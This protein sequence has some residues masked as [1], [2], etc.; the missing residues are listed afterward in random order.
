MSSS[1]GG[2]KTLRMSELKKNE[3]SEGSSSSSSSSSS[4]GSSNSISN[5]NNN[6]KENS[7]NKQANNDATNMLEPFRLETY[8]A[9]YEFIAKHLLCCR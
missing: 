5:N 9:K 4:G 1:A 7:K 6:D 2:V 3:M 8:F